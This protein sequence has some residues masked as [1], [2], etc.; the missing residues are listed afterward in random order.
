MAA[1]AA[2]APYRLPTDLD[3]GRIQAIV[4]AKVKE[5]KDHLLAMRED[6]GYFLECIQC[7]GEHRQE[8]VLDRNVRKDSRIGKLEFWDFVLGSMIS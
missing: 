3:F 5:L 6:P 7:Q 4:A 8:H 2:E 1:L